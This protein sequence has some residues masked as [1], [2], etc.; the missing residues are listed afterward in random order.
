MK[1]LDGITILEL[2]TMITAS[3]ASMMMGEQGARVI[4]VEPID[5]GDPMRYLGSAKG[6]ISALFANCNRGKQ[7]L[8]VDLKAE[9]GQDI[10]RQ[11]AASCD[12]VIHNFR[13]GVMDRL[14]LGSER[15]RALNPRLR[16]TAISGFGNKGP[17]GDAPA[18]DPVIQAHAGLAASQGTESPEFIRNLMCDKITAYTAT[19][20]VIAALYQREKT[21]EGQ[22]IDLSMLD[23]GLF[24]I[25]PDGFMNY[26]LLDDDVEP[27]PALADFLYDLTYTKDGAMTISAASDR[28]R[29]GVLKALNMEHLMED[30]RFNTLET[31]LANIDL[32]RELLADSFLAL[33][34]EEALEKLQENNVPC[35]RCLDKNE[36]LAQ[37]Q[38]K[39][40]GSIEV[41]EHPLMGE[42]RVVKLPARFGGKVL[43]AGSHSP[44]HGEHTDE[45]LASLNFSD[46]KIEDLKTQGVVQ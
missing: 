27:L 13:P 40:N 3:F 46:E 24:F 25:F 29:M 37:E 1:P 21:G 7:S 16:Y 36:V 8:R 14:N 32:Y 28:Q 12:V 10:V 41:R 2:S 23:A 18:Y 39:V 44:A 43:D 22:H 33:T 9:S 11:I 26:T 35:A 19:Q 42:M 30:P 20:A 17:L 6:G 4:K 45:I 38:L 5:A 31:M 15:L 34:T